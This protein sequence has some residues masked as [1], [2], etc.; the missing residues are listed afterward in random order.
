VLSEKGVSHEWADCGI[1]QLLGHN[2]RSNDHMR[3]KSEA[4]DVAASCER[5]GLP[6]R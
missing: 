6:I 1:G 2:G 5:D 3:T 4:I